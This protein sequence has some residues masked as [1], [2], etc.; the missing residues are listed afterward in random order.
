MRRRL[1]ILGR[2]L[3]LDLDVP[4]EAPTLLSLW[5][6]AR[7]ASEAIMRVVREREALR[8]V[9]PTCREGCSACCL[10]L[11][12]I[13]TIEAVRLARLVDAL[14]A[15][16]RTAVRARFDD[17]L[18]RLERAGL[19]DA[20]APRGRAAMTTVVEEGESLWETLSRRYRALAVA[21]P[22][23]VHQ[24]CSIYD[25]RPLICREY[26]VS[27]PPAECA[28]PDGEVLAFPR[29]VRLSEAL[30][31]AASE[32]TGDVGSIPLVLTLEWAGTHAGPLDAPRAADALI[33]ALDGAIM[34]ERDPVR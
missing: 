7:A 29:P 19:L 22:F 31:E 24:R 27:S 6:P 28:A 33:M 4:G 18:R 21:C 30:G 3:D 1:Q 12:P 15:A 11:I 14:P 16:R 34:V 13:S 10:H 26:L 20:R 25:E 17:A 5:E 32:T 9:T 2:S 8:G 23:L